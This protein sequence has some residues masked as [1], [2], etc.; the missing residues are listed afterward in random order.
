MPG[1]AQGS[2]SKGQHILR[3]FAELPRFSDGRV[4]FTKSKKAPVV[5]CFVKY[6][7]KILLLK[8]SDKVNVYKGVWNS[9]GGYYDEP[10]EIKEKVLE[11]LREELGILPEDIKSLKMFPGVKFFDPVVKRTWIVYP[12]LAELK[13]LPEIKL[14]WEHTE[15]K[16]VKPE[17]LKN[18]KIVY[19]LDKLLK[20]VLG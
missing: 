1:P 4:D 10:V 7:D 5:N 9:I 13:R 15:Y 19:K 16:W 20:R 18:F 14:D 17:E 8:R 3:E 6:Q 11:E 2:R 12:A